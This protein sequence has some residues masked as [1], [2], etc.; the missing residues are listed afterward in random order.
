MPLELL[1][2]VTLITEYPD[3]TIYGDAFRLAHTTQ[4]NT[5]LA[6][7]ALYLAAAAYDG[8]DG[9]VARGLVRYAGSLKG[10]EGEDRFFALADTKYLRAETR[11]YVPKLIAAALVG[12]EPARYGV[13]VESLPPFVFDSVRVRGATPLAAVANA[14]GTDTGAIRDLNPELLRGMTP[15]ADS[16]W[17]RIRAGAARGFAE[18]F[19]SLGPEE[20]S[21]VG[22]A[23]RTWRKL[24]SR[25]RVRPAAIGRFSLSN[26]ILR[27]INGLRYIRQPSLHN[28]G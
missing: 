5:V 12:K 10:V 25:R 14:A 20:R 2:P 21:A 6:A 7:A 28:S 23:R 11:D 13:A 17:V 3:E 16:V 24:T 1:V 15:P 9:R 4:M 26:R 19:S 8:G 18:R 27:P 22:S